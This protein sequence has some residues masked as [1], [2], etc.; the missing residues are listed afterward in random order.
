MKSKLVFSGL[1][2][3]DA[4]KIGQYFRHVVYQG[5]AKWQVVKIDGSPQYV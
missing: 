2:L 4:P 1:I 3:T 5:F